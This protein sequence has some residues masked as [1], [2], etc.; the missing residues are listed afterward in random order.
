MY[1][2]LSLCE[3]SPSGS[4]AGSDAP[5]R[6]SPISANQGAHGLPR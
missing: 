1:Y 3:Y 6:A 5:A 2:L 4:F